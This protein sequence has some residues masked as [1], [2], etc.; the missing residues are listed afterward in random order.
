M[1]LEIDDLH[2][3]VDGKEILKGHQLVDPRGRSACGH[4]PERLG[5]VDAVLCAGRPRGLR[6]HRGRIL[7]RGEDL[8]QLAPEERAAKGVFLAFQYPV[9]IPGRRHHDFLKTALN[10]QRRARGETE[11][12]AREG[13]EARARKGEGA[14][15]RR[16]H[17]EAR[18]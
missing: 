9:E 5:Q 18:R 2:V 11:L 7:Y 15:C 13:A 12:D 4:G 8:T 1:M 17:A 14:Q 10:A 3:T 6:G 16:R